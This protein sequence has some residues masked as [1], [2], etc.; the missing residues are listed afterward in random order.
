MGKEFVVI[1]A[2]ATTN[3]FTVNVA[4]LLVALPAPLLATTLNCESLSETE[5]EVIAYVD[6]VALLIAAPFLIHWYAKGP[7]PVAATKKIAG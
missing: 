7:V 1:V 6:E 2:G 4:V 3:W 5:V